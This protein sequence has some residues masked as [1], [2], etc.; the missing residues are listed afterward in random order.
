MKNISLDSDL[1]I[2][3]GVGPKKQKVLENFGLKKISDLLYFFPR[4]YLDRNFTGDFFLKAGE[5]VTFLAE[6]KSFYTA[7][8]KKSRLIAVCTT[9][10]GEQIELVFFRGLEF[11]RKIIYKGLQLAV[12]GKLENFRGTFQIVHPEYETVTEDDPSMLKHTGR[13]IPLYPSNETLKNEGLDSKGFRR[14]QIQIQDW[15]DEGRISVPEIIP[16]E[17]AKKR[18]L[19]SRKDAFLEIHFPESFE[20]LKDAQFRFAYEELYFFSILME[21]KKNLRNEFKRKLWPLPDSKTASE[22]IKT[23]PFSLTED[24]ENA[25]SLLRKSSS[26]DIPSAALLQGDVGSGKTVTALIYA[27]H[28]TDNG[29][30]TVIMAPTEILARQHY[31]SIMNLLGNRIFHGVELVIGKDREKSRLEKLDRIRRGE[32]L[33][34]IGTHSLLQPDVRF[35][36]LGLVIIDEQHKFGVEQRETLR[37]KGKNPD[38]LAMTATPI[39]RT[40]CLT[41]YGDLNLIT[42]RNK[43]KGRKPIVTKWF[44]EDRRESV[45]SS[46]KKYL[47]QGRQAYIVYPIIEESEKTDMQSCLEGFESLRNVYFTEFRAG[48][49]HG[50]M[51]TAEKEKVMADFKK[52]DVDLLVTTTVVEV[53]VDVPNA[54][55]LVIENADRFGISQ[56]HQLRGRV[57]RG[58]HESFCILLTKNFVS[59]DAEARLEAVC[60]SE[61]GFILSEK[62]LQI[63]GP[64]ELLGTRQSGLPDFKIADLKE[65]GSILEMAKED[66]LVSSGI[67]EDVKHEIR[68]RFEEGSLLFP[69]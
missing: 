47:K 40:L 41:L 50:K 46:M 6:I 45:Y 22:L 1:S 57:G 23:L 51:K 67:T 56:L 18:N 20:S 53:G 21:Y 55:V 35:S 48:L 49:L 34:V 61:D 14:L 29:I 24:Q 27:L 69:N 32:S 60:S 68:E 3:S 58:E 30:Q 37:S 9:N 39:P 54:A 19:K 62:D 42:I 17:L 7:H 8:G 28:Y 44:K 12:T 33:I 16:P 2:L 5:T 13:I 59:D 10:R 11:F 52:G 26:G 31:I 25:V 38:L 15:I 66:S 65:D 63:R 64:G 43:P 36:D 4:K